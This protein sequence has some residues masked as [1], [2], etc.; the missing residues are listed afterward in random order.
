MQSL[1]VLWW[2]FITSLKSPYEGQNR[3]VEEDK[4]G[5]VVG[6]AAGGAALH[7]DLTGWGNGPT[8]TAGISTRSGAKSSTWGG[9]TP[10]T[11]ACLGPPSFSEK[12][13]EVLVA[14][15]WNTIHQCV[16]LLQRRPKVTLG[17]IRQCCQQAEGDDSSLQHCCGHTQSPVSISGSPVQVGKDLLE[18]V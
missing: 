12:D 14:T 5:G 9:T 13:W 4:L 7:R 17:C 15:K 10:C 1:Y 8:G 16:S 3:A 11:N 2:H 6:A 18:G